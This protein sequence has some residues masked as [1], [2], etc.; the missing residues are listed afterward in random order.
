MPDSGR[1][2]IQRDAST[3]SLKVADGGSSSGTP[4][5]GNPDLARILGGTVFG[6]PG[7]IISV[8][9][10]SEGTTKKGQSARLIRVKWTAEPGLRFC[11]YF[12]YSYDSEWKQWKD[13]TFNHGDYGVGKCGLGYAVWAGGGASMAAV[14]RQRG[15]SGDLPKAP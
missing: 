3:P 11:S 13:I 7:R 10:V 2:A 15:Y 1:A 5:I 14:L 12:L 6:D 8:E 4:L 9:P